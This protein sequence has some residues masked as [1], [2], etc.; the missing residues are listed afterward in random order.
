MLIL[1][2]PITLIILGDIGLRSPQTQIRSSLL[3]ISV[4]QIKMM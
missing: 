3:C 2:K 4:A 1:N